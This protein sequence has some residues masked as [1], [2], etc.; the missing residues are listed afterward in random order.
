MF[1]IVV[2]GGAPEADLIPAEKCAPARDVA[3]HQDA[4]AVAPV[5]A[6]SFPADPLTGDSPIGD[7]WRRPVRCFENPASCID[8]RE[9]GGTT[10][11]VCNR[12]SFD[13]RMRELRS[14]TAASTPPRMASMSGSF[15]AIV[16]DGPSLPCYATSATPAG[17]SRCRPSR[18]GTPG[19]DLGWSTCSSHAP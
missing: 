10:V 4:P 19:T 9:P 11:G 7:G 8:W 5:S 16:L 12:V 2:A 13:R 15:D 6:S 18:F 14:D 17:G 1:L 3:L